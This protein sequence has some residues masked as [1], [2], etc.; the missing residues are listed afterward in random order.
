MLHAC[1]KGK[2]KCLPSA[3]R[4]P[5]RAGGAVVPCT[6]RRTAC[7][8]AQSDDR[9]AGEV[10]GWSGGF[11]RRWS[12]QPRNSWWRDDLLPS[13]VILMVAE[14]LRG[15]VIAHRLVRKH[16]GTM[17]RRGERRLP[18]RVFCRE[19][20]AGSAV[21]RALTDSLNARGE[22]AAAVELMVLPATE[23]IVWVYPKGY[24]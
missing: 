8:L 19:L 21:G 12:A 1:N 9:C 22:I 16:K 18:C 6:R 3:R 5:P 10:G 11:D 4:Q 17:R 23:F 14:L 20:A 7:R 13:L 15:E 2:Q 24:T